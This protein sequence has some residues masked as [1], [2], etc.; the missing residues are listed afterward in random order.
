MWAA[1]RVLPLQWEG[2]AS[3]FSRGGSFGF[4]YEIT[5]RFK[6][7]GQIQTAPGLTAPRASQGV[8]VIPPLCLW[9]SPA[10]SER[11]PGAAHEHPRFYR[12]HWL[13]ES[14]GCG[15]PAPQR[16]GTTLCPV[17]AAPCS[18]RPQLRCAQP[19]PPPPGVREFTCETCGKSFKRKN[20]LEVHRRTHTGETPLQ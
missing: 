19:C 15:S 9:L 20:H 4:V 3:D 5:P 6:Y 8:Q 12:Q 7:W 11:H 18:P 13:P 10:A 17:S 16:G 1:T 14:V 2:M